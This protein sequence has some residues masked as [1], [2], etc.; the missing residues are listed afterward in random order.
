MEPAAHDR[1]SYTRMRLAKLTVSG[2]KSFADRTEIAFNAPLVG[3]V[4]PNGC[5]KSNVVDAIKWVLGEQSAKQLRGG[6]MLDVIFNGSATRKP[7][8]MASVTLHFDNPAD[9]AGKR[10]LPVEADEVAVT[11]RLFRDGTSEYLVNKQKARLRDIR[12]LFYDTGI[13]ANAYCIIEQ[14]KVD[15][16]LVSN[17]TDRRII[18]EEAA[19]IA[20]FKAQK[21]EAIRKLG[22]TEQNLLRSRDKL[23]EVQKRLRSVK[24]QAT[25]ARNYQEY[26][27]RLRE[28]RLEYALA[29]YHKLQGELERVSRELAEAE[30]ARRKA[31]AQLTAAEDQK[32]AAE[33]ERQQLLQRQR[34]LEQTCLQLQSQRDQAAQ[35]RQ[36]ALTT[37]AD[38]QE[39]IARERTQQEELAKRRT[40]LD[41]QLAEHEAVMT[42][43]QSRVAV[44]QQRIDEA[45]ELHRVRQHQL[46]DAQAQLEDEKAGIVNLLRRTTQMHNLI[47]SL[48]MQEKNLIGHRDRLTTR[49]DQ[50]AGELEGLLTTRD[51]CEPQLR[52]VLALIETETA[53]LEEQK[54]AAADLSDATRRL[55][56][57]L[58]AAKE[59]RSAL[60][61]RR[62]VLQELEES[63]T[64]VDD[65]VKAVLARKASSD[66][67]TFVRGLLAEMIGADVKHAAI[68]E[69]ALG[70]DQQA[71][72]V[73]T[74]DAVGDLASLSGRVRF[75]AIDQAPA[76]RFDGHPAADC[77]CVIDY[78]SYDAAIASVVWKLLGKTLVVN[79]LATAR[80]L[81]DELAAGYRFVTRDGQVLE[82]DATLIAGPHGESAGAGLISRRSE[83]AELQRRIA[84]LD[85]EISADQ[86]HLAQLSDRAAHVER[87]QQELR[88]AIYEASTMKVELNSRLAQVRD[89]IARIE[90]EQPVI[91]GE[92]EQIHRQLNDAESK[93]REHAD[94]VAR[95]EEEQAQSKAR[96]AELEGKIVGFKSEAEQS[97]EAVTAARVEAGKISEQLTAAS[98]QQRQLEL[99]RDDA[100]R[101]AQQVRHR[102]D[103]HTQRIGEL[104]KTRD[105]AAEQI[106]LAE[107]S[108]TDLKRTLEGFAGDLER[109]DAHVNALAAVV[110]EQRQVAES[111]D[112][113]SH[114]HQVAQRE[115]EVR[116]DGVRERSREQLSLDIAEAYADYQAREID[117]DAVESEI[118]ELKQ[119]VERLGTVNL[120]AINEQTELEAREIE[121][122]NQLADIDK[123]RVELENLIT[124]LNDESRTR[125]E[126]TFM[127][128]REHFA[129]ND[130]LFRKLFGG[131]RADLVLMPDENGNTDWLESGI[132]IIAKP[133]GKEPQSIR[134]LSGGERTMVAV[135][136]L[137][138][139]FRSRPSPF[140]V[141]DEVDA[142]LDEANVDRFCHVVRSFLDLSHFI[143]I[144]HHKRTMQA[145]DLLYG[146][147]MPIRGVSKQVTVRF[148]QVGAGG[149]IAD[150]A[151]RNIDTS[152][153]AE[154][155]EPLTLTA[156]PT[157]APAD[158]PAARS[159]NAKR[160]AAM[161]EDHE[162]VE[163]TGS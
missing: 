152:P 86:T 40:T 39:Q 77:E 21:N 89:A 34:E 23:E 10:G 22:R 12:N 30:E 117:W 76:M 123:A 45:Q 130:G 134:L 124:Y 157:E 48:E 128:I 121:L 113:Q 84:D 19:G 159:S 37:L 118:T 66:E 16:M 6:A 83:L 122:T 149:K 33:S 154:D 139:I 32:Q 126:Q 93:K 70:I 73:D 64:G 15:K 132:E 138:S 74:L 108:I 56:E 153:V 151:L 67:F 55:T 4:G 42:D 103:Q 131:G 102:L 145:A 107:R 8:G 163:V 81:H 125:F 63:Q 90:K 49:A 99:A 156:A 9:D 100:E 52:E 85:T 115:L 150:D 11:R 87:V 50:L 114:N 75:M 41:A 78:V 96:A 91:S 147:T 68:V 141:L 116:C 142:A 137:M 24:I 148:D 46:N 72:V 92:V 65:A 135:A 97:A 51:T 119:K 94:D 62:K 5:G 155:D 60:V 106:E 13:G 3:I 1:R 58:A 36:F 53:R 133:P 98:R 18:F 69:A 17:P 79:D 14:G 136:L 26:T 112:A 27:A 59:E 25:R 104:E 31:V 105:E 43:L 143:V 146:I 35:R 20:K 2:F 61:S 120:D 38:V 144:T 127:Q 140:C 28:L 82:A 162:K 129:A 54:T 29:E 80:R 88:Q 160:L 101:Q 57:Q 71:L 44:S 95:L 7:A 110:R 161:M 111:L 47:A 158:A 109:I